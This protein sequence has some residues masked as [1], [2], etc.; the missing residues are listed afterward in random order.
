[1]FAAAAF[2]DLVPCGHQD[3]LVGLAAVLPNCHL[4]DGF[5]GAWRTGATEV[6]PR[7]VYPRRPVLT[8]T[9]IN[10]VPASQTI[11]IVRRLDC[12][13]RKVGL[14]KELGVDKV[15]DSRLVKVGPHS[16]ESLRRSSPG[17]WP[18]NNRAKESKVLDCVSSAH[19][20]QLM[21]N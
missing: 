5:T 20:G 4:N 1:M 11:V 16:G 6:R 15:L 10:R 21:G 2:F 14:W 17:M 13:L 18:S 3:V 9:V 12:E 19:L 8:V 7:V